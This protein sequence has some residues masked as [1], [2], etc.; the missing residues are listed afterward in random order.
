MLYYP[1]GNNSYKYIPT[2]PRYQMLHFLGADDDYTKSLKAL[3]ESLLEKDAQGEDYIVQEPPAKKRKRQQAAHIV[4]INSTVLWQD[5]GEDLNEKFNY[6][7]NVTRLL[8]D[9]FKEELIMQGCIAW[10][11]HSD[12]ADVC[13]MNYVVPTTGVLSPNAFVHVMKTTDY[14]GQYII[15]CTCSIFDFIRHAAHHA[16]PHWPFADTYPDVETSCPHCQFYNEFL[17]DAFETASNNTLEDL[18]VPLC[19]VKKSLGYF[20]EEVLL[21]GNVIPSSTTK[22]R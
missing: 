17:Q 6:T 1:E 9:N 7:Q 4:R 22:F 13:I 18:N 12:E 10:C 11:Y 15:K 20:N 2:S 19:M 3:I 5:V 8:Y 14:A 21:L 16:N